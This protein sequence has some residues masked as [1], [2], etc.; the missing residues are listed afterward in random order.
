[1]TKLELD[2]FMNELAAELITLRERLQPSQADEVR[3]L[4]PTENTENPVV[5][6]N[7]LH[8]ASND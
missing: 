3:T 4:F 7:T 8:C 5:C 2:A 1:M 6:G